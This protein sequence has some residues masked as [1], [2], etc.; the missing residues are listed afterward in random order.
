MKECPECGSV[1]ADN[2]PYCENCGFDPGFDA[3]SWGHGSSRSR[4]VQ[5]APKK[6]DK[7]QESSLDEAIGC[8]FL[9][10]MVFFLILTIYF[11]IS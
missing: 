10:I 11:Y 9:I 2:E 1:L 4:S 7:N 3:G 6:P 8:I 5:Y